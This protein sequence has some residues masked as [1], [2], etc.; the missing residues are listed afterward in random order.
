LSSTKLIVFHQIRRGTIIIDYISE[1]KEKK[2]KLEMGLK[3]DDKE[4]ESGV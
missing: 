4:K 3:R 2:K 1:E